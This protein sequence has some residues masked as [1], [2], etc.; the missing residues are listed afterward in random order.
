MK[1][2][3]LFKP[4]AD[5]NLLTTPHIMTD[6]TVRVSDVFPYNRIHTP[7]S[8]LISNVLDMSRWAAANLKR[9]EL[10]GKRILQESTYH[11]LWHPSDEQ[12]PQIG[13]GWFLSEHRGHR[14]VSHGGSDTGY[15]SHLVLVPDLSL[16]VVAMSN[17][18]RAPIQDL[19]LA[20]LDVLLT[21]EPLP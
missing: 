16:G 4:D 10:D 19:A 2:S 15:R 17:Y 21:S 8:T 6:D 1:D 11:T 9:G 18:H 5:L 14:T 3:T 13:I 20:A 7:S 12:F